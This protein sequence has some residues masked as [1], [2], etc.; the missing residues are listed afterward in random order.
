MNGP[1]KGFS[2]PAS[3]WGDRPPKVCELSSCFSSF[4]GNR[5]DDSPHIILNGCDSL[6]NNRNFLHTPS[7]RGVRAP[8]PKRG[9]P[10]EF[11]GPIQGILYF[12]ESIVAVRDQSRFQADG[13][14]ESLGK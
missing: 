11:T 12:P 6:T 1:L 8:R 3:Q 2:A 4:G 10:V 9:Y 7:N 14:A 13:E 5:P